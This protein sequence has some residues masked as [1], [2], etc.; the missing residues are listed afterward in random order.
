M[1]KHRLISLLLVAAAILGVFFIHKTQGNSASNGNGQA[2]QSAY[3]F[4][5]GLDLSGGT[6]LVYQADVSQIPSG[7]VDAAMQTLHDVIENRVNLVGVS[8]PLIQTQST[9]A[10]GGNTEQLIVELP[11]VTDVNQ[12]VA[13]IGQTPVLDFK[14]VNDAVAKTIT[15]DATTTP[16]NLFIPTGLTGRF[17]SGATLQ[18][19]PQNQPY[20][21]VNF[22]ADGTKLFAQ[23]TKTNVGKELAIFLDG[24]VISSPTIQEEIPDGSAQI[25]GGFTA[26]QASTLVRDLNYGALPVPITLV[27]T[28][29]IG[30]S[31]GEIA[32]HQSVNAGI[33]AFI[34]IVAFLILWYRLPG[35]IASIALA[36][37]VVIMLVIFKVGGIVLT[38]AGLAGFILSIGMAVDANILIFERMK[39]ELR[40]GKSIEVAIH[41][42]FSRAWP[43]IRDSNFSSILTAFI[44]FYFSSTPTI[45]GF[46][47]IF[48][49]GV[50]ASM[51]TAIS[52]SR[53]FLFA[54]ANK[55]A[56][57]FA[58]FL[59]SN[60]FKK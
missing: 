28:Q 29:K 44:L 50:L 53:T 12:A 22:N 24:R 11:G 15:A 7:Q 19:N 41:E 13:M 20:V 47:L 42:G 26:D 52:I 38:A 17:I 34:L 4:K 30:A 25:T 8:E 49:I 21:L 14:L 57:K 16:A 10:L 27:G 46:A 54:I 32:L 56:G 6:H 58:R 33:I 40:A 35:L 60:G 36:L 2:S 43:S 55:K 59:F 45:K 1:N 48:G 23:I 5:L 18:Y 51:L 9:G 31:L 37:Y 39:E 3:A